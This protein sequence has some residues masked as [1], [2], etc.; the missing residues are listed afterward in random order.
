MFVDD[1]S[2]WATGVGAQVSAQQLCCVYSSEEGRLASGALGQAWHAQ[3][4][5]N[6]FEQQARLIHA[7]PCH[8]WATQ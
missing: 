7:P 4:G 3:E 5:I 6:G 2:E 1:L 8:Q